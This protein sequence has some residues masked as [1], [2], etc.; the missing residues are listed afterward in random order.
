LESHLAEVEKVVGMLQK[1]GS[2]GGFGEGGW[3]LEAERKTS[4]PRMS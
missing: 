4:R 3:P 1:R 2:R